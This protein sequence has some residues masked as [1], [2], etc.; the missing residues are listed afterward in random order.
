MYLYLYFA[1]LLLGIIIGSIRFKNLNKSN[2]IFL[3]LLLITFISET[4]SLYLRKYGLQKNFLQSHIFHPIQFTIVAYAYF[5]ELRA[6]VILYLIILM[7]VWEIIL[8]IFI[9]PIS[10]Y[11]TYF[12][13]L[14][15]LIF[16]IFSIV[17]LYKLLKIKTEYSIVNFPLFWIS[18]GLLIFSIANLFFFGT[19]N[20]FFGE[21]SSLQELFMYIRF[22]TNYVLY[23]LFIIAFLVKQYTL[24]TDERK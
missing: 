22:F 2:K 1:I 11:D 9:Q 4:L 5:V 16:S 7:T 17:Y 13:N 6:K 24:L 8:T 3:L 19:Y 23:G 14:E 10:L 21:K 20:T 15:L 18:C 12:I